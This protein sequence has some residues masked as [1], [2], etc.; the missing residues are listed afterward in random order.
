M[1]AAIYQIL[2]EIDLHGE[3]SR[4]ISLCETDAKFTGNFIF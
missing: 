4:R 2:G 1:Q 3:F